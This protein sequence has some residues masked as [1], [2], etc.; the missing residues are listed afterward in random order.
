[1]PGYSPSMAHIILISSPIQSQIQAHIHQI[2]H[3]SVTS[4]IP[5]SYIYLA[6]SKRKVTYT[7]DWLLK[8][9]GKSWIPP[10]STLNEFA[11]QIYFKLGGDKQ[12][13]NALS[14]KLILH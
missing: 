14:Q 12:S 5:P 10:V 2:L 8:P 9:A 6:P 7:Q 4:S 11:K 1:M 13:I 3:N